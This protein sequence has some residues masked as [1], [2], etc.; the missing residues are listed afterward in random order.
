M[1]NDFRPINLAKKDEVKIS[2]ILKSAK[3][4]IDSKL[5]G[6]VKNEQLPKA[7][8]DYMRKN[9]FNEVD[10]CKMD[11][12]HAFIVSNGL[13]YPLLR[14]VGN[15]ILRAISE[16]ENKL[17]LVEALAVFEENI[18]IVLQGGKVEKDFIDI[19]NQSSEQEIENKFVFRGNVSNSSLARNLES[20]SMEE[21]SEI[22]EK[23]K[24]N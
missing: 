2:A 4:F 13:I 16:N 22:K 14:A 11:I 17:M 6:L 9:Y 21:Q 20:Q 5:D 1:D 15:C 19:M 10:A 7:T 23:L 12:K 8:A 18:A 24:N 3:E